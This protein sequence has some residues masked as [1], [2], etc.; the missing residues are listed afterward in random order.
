MIDEIIKIL[1]EINEISKESKFNECT[2]KLQETV[3]LL[4]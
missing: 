4:T 1:H 2:L 3:M